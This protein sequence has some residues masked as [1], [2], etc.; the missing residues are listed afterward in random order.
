MQLLLPPH[1]S[2]LMQENVGFLLSRLTNRAWFSNFSIFTNVAGSAAKSMRKTSKVLLY[3]PFDS[4]ELTERST[5][6]SMSPQATNHGLTGKG[7]HLI[8]TSCML[9]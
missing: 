7:S 9:N 2:G 1:L 6:R 8:D 3:E 5:M 4:T